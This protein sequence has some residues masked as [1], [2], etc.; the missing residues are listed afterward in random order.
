[1][2]DRAN[3]NLGRSIVLRVQSQLRADGEP[4]TLAVEA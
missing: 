1:M 3:P 4:E 2:T